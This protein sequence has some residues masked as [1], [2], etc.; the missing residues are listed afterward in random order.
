MNFFH[1]QGNTK[2]NEVPLSAIIP[3]MAGMASAGSAAV[4]MAAMDPHVIDAHLAVQATI[5]SY[6]VRGHLAAQIDPLKINNMSLEAA[7]KMIIR[8]TTIYEQD[9]DTVFQLPSTTWI[10][11]KVS[12]SLFWFLVSNNNQA[13]SSF[14]GESLAFA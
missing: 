12:L 1:F 7:K 11:G 9:M 6:Q 5:R 10:G 4:G 14:L 3:S 8:S 2:A 13:T